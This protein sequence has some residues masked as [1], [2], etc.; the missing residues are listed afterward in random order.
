MIC[1]RC[2]Y[3]C[4]T[5]AV[6]LPTGIPKFSNQPCPYLEWEEE[7]AICKIYGQS[8]DIEHDGHT[9]HYTWKETPCGRHSQIEH[10]NTLCRMGEYLRGRG[11]SGK[12]FIQE[13][14]NVLH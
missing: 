10:T 9:Y 12:D 2:G 1:L 13:R 8:F 5:S 14:T 3:C 4:V 6:I 11:K 7:K